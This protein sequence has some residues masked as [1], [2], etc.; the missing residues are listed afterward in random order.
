LAV[1]ENISFRGY[2]II[3]IL[4]KNQQHEIWLAT[5][6]ADGQK[7]VLKKSLI[8]HENSPNMN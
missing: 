1:E 8:Y 2:S 3:K 7:V 5:R 4:A 6:E